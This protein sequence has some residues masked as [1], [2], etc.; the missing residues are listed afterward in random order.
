MEDGLFSE[1]VSG[2]WG[3]GQLYVGLPFWWSFLVVSIVVDVIVFVLVRCVIVVAVICYLYAGSVS[4]GDV[5]C[6]G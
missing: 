5:A 6:F 1:G 4:F 2:G 3:C